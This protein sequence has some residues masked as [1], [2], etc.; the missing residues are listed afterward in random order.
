MSIIW[1]CTTTSKAEV[2]SSASIILGLSDVAIAKATRCFIPPLSSCGYIS[3]TL[4]S[5]PTL[6]SNSITRSVITPLFG[7]SRLGV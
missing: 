1:R 6:L 4:E 3:A 5:R 7:I 2:G